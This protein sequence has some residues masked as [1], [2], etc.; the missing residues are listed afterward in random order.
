MSRVWAVVEREL[1]GSFRSPVAYA[2]LAV[3]LFLHG[4]FF[5]QLMEEYSS[6][7]FQ[8][9]TNAE[10]VPE[11]NLVDMVARP[12][13]MGDS[14]LLLMLLPAMTMRLLAEEWR[15]GTGDL[16]LSYPLRERE[17]VAG[18]FIAACAL[19]FVLLASGL[20]YPVAAGLLGQVEFPVLAVGFLGLLLYGA[21]ILGVGLFFSSLTDNQVIAMVGTVCAL[22]AFTLAGFWSARVGD[23]WSSTLQHMSLRQHMQPFSYGVV[24]LSDCVFFASV[25]GFFL[26]L[27]VGRLES[28]RWRGRSR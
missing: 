14:F 8:I 7:S 12:L 20:V 16:L 9:L 24:R 19:L 21:A 13:L 18:K 27:T 23:P 3:Y 6:R 22:L 1:R 5:V 4:L 26:Y 11:H 2:I 15:Q 25:T 17:I 28:V 10:Q